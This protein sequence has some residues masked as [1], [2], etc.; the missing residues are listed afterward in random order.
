MSRA[1]RSPTLG[2]ILGLVITLA[3]VVTYSAYI[4]HQIS[5]LRE[6]QRN[7]V[8]RNRK[9]SIQLL[10]IQ[11]DLNTLGL[12]MRDMLSN[13]SGFPVDA[14]ANQFGRLRNDMADAMKL[15]AE[16]S[17]DVRTP[18][19]QQFL[20]DTFAQFFAV[21]ADAFDMARNG[22]NLA[23]RD[24]IRLAMQPR[25]EALSNAVARLL[26]ANNESEERAAARVH[27]IYDGV[28]RQVYFFL[29]ATLAAILLT[30]IFLISS[31]RRLFA[32][33]ETLSQQRSELAQRLITTQESTLR[34]IS[35]ELHDEF[36]QI[37]TAI[38]SL[39]SRSES[40]RPKAPPFATI[41]TRCATSPKRL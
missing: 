10:R 26:V 17:P 31:N 7:L 2:L 35:R 12:S 32:Q 1:D 23:A 9:D 40:R 37:L 5:G 8:D 25:Q 18:E 38:G 30:S 3:A 24:Q 21:A 39:L 11:N 15:E 20:F 19:Q 29:T 13:E 36:G 27:E 6:L 34:H 16:L 22:D 4:T 14:W 41:C 33:V 28:Q